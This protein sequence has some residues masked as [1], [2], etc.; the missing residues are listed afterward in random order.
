MKEKKEKPGGGTNQDIER[1]YCKGKKKIMKIDFFLRG[2]NILLVTV[3]F[4]PDIDLCM[5]ESSFLPVQ[6]VKIDAVHATAV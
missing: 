3:L 5:L 4:E 2:E 6:V 1:K